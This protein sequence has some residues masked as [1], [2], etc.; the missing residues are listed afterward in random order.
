MNKQPPFLIHPNSYPA[1]ILV[2]S[3]HF[4]MCEKNSY[5]VLHPHFERS[6][7]RSHIW[8]T[9]L[10]VLFIGQEV[11][12]SIFEKM[13]I[14]SFSWQLM[15]RCRPCQYPCAGCFLSRWQLASSLYCI[16]AHWNFTVINNMETELETLLNSPLS[17]LLLASPLNYY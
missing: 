7:L 5:N 8:E 6:F 11:S 3:T 1:F 16:Q 13:G 17:D 10:A 14:L 12:I 4:G 15:P 2:V 9:T